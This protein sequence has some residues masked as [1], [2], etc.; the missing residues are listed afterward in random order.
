MRRGAVVMVMLMILA[1]AA[2]GQDPEK[3]PVVLPSPNLPQPPLVPTAAASSEYVELQVGDRAPDFQLDGSLGRPVR[4]ADLKGHWAVLVFDETRTKLGRLSAV[5]DS[6]RALGARLYGICPDRVGA[7]KTFAGREG[8]ACPLL[9]D[10][11][12]E[13]SKLFGMYDDAGGTVQSGL[14]LVDP[15]GV[16]RGVFQGPSLHPDDVLQLVR[17]TVAGS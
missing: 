8:V 15:Q 17:H 5:D 14:L 6:I 16:I 12:R 13:V 7:L 1:S 2:W 9:A 4:L 3:H 11:T 10:P